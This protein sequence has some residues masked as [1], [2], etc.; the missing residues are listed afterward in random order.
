[1]D[2]NKNNEAY[3]NNMY[4]EQNGSSPAYGGQNYG[5][6]MYGNQGSGQQYW[7]NTNVPAQQHGG[8]QMHGTPM[9]NNGQ[10]YNANVSGSY[11][12]DYNP[13]MDYNPIGMWGYFGYNLLFMIPIVGFICVL[14]FA[15][16]GTKNVNLRNYA[17]SM[18]CIWIIAIVLAMI[19]IVIAAS[20]GGG[21]RH[22][23][24]W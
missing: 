10:M 8:N 11:I 19:S 21:R 6:G 12:R 15:F 7:D 2:N 18:F 9:G 16:G 5:N 14:V 3:T 1:M 4:A 23:Y 22:L 20:V 17:R 13:N 24:Y